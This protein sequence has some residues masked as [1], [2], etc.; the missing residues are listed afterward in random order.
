MHGF[1]TTVFF[2]GNIILRDFEVL[3][4]DREYFNPW[5]YCYMML[6]TGFFDFHNFV[7][8]RQPNFKNKSMML[9]H[10]FSRFCLLM[11]ELYSFQRPFFM[12]VE[13]MSIDSLFRSLCKPFTCGV[14]K[15]TFISLSFSSYLVEHFATQKFCKD[16]IFKF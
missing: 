2:A 15:L 1:W 16:E 5:G 4:Y 10:V 13:T 3:E 7:S 12:I 6:K 8:W 14:E 11:A 9:N